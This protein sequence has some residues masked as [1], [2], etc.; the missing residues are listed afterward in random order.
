MPLV[1]RLTP[2]VEQTL[3]QAGSEREC[4][5]SSLTHVGEVLEFVIGFCSPVSVL[6]SH[7]E[8]EEKQRA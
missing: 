8:H 6:V 5:S 4:R 1:V 2:L 7:T 3:R